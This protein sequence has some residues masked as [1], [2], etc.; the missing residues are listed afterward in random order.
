L[1]IRYAKAGPPDTEAEARKPL[2]GPERDAGRSDEARAGDEPAE[3]PLTFA[4]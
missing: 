4:Y 2:E 1:I 3:Q